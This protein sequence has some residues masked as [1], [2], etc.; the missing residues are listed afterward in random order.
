M[1]TSEFI[2]F[3]GEFIRWEEAKIHV[4]SHVAHYGSGVFEGLRAYATPG[5][6]AV[7]GLAAHVTRLFRSCKIMDLPLPFTRVQISEAIIA[8]VR[9]NGH[10][11]C[12][13]RPLVFRGYGELGVLPTGCPVEFIIATLEWGTLHGAEAL[14]KGVD[15]GVSSFRRIAPDTHPAMAKAVGNYVNSQMIIL[16]AKRHGYAEGIVLDSEGF[17]CEASGANVFL[18]YD[19]A[20]Y[21]PPI[22]ES[23]LPGVTRSYVIQLAQDLGIPVRQE[24]IAREMLYMADEVFMTGTA[25]EITPVRSVDR[26]RVGSG[27]RGPVATILQQAFFGII[28]GERPDLHGWLTHVNAS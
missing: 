8:T 11:A 7:L 27:T 1:Q 25:A 6:P 22:G 2:W 12:Y 16:E 28:R 21:T 13:I 24:R 14:E 19:N 9:Q 23:I 3:N 4:L 5:G 17:V 20:L 18:V 10:A 26:R 15:V